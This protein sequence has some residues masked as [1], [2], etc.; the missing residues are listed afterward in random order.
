MKSSVPKP[1]ETGAEDVQETASVDLAIALFCAVLVLFVFV[2]S[3]L[4][5]DPEAPPLQT[6]AQTKITAP[7]TLPSY[8]PVNER[9]SFLLMTEDRIFHINLPEIGRGIRDRAVQY[10]ADDGYHLFSRGTGQSPAEFLLTINMSVKAPPTVW[11]RSEIDLAEKCPGDLRPILTVFYLKSSRL[12]PSLSTWAEKCGM[13]VRYEPVSL[14][15]D[16]RIGMV[17]LALNAEVY[18][19]DRIFR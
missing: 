15:P 1:S 6:L 17:T 9:T 13:R 4:D 8:S 2:A 11:I 12:F 10:S 14:S 18:S 7:M 3:N 5:R 16:G 19:A